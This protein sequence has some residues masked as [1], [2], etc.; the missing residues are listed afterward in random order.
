MT[1]TLS[2]PAPILV[3][4]A[5]G[6]TGRRVTDRLTDAG[7]AVR[8]AS[9][10]GDHPFDWT[11]PATWTAAVDGVGAAYL[12]Y[13]P[14]LAL[15]GARDAVT[16]VAAALAGQGVQRVVLLSGRGEALA[17]D[18]ERAFLELIPT[19]T[20]VRCAF[21]DQNFTEG[22][23]AGAVIDGMLALPGAAEI[24]EPFLDADDIADVVVAAL[25]AEG[26]EHEGRVLELTGPRSVSLAE[27]AEILGQA[28]GHPV[29]YQ[30]VSAADFAA[31]AQAAGLPAEEAHGLAEL[32]VGL[33][34]GHNSATTTT[35]ADVLGHPARSLEDFASAA[36]AAGAW[37][38]P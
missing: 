1:T 24:T 28:A 30:Q 2:T 4:G 8:R 18:C 26:V 36:A 27:T 16:G 35:V 25:L 38:R 29:I 19:G 7:H 10:S 11:D 37:R 14:D 5:N 31:H 22:P 32:F 15:P 17:Q 20:V 34:D 13:Q 9:R 33:L 3:T 23:F 6:K 21:F 12:T